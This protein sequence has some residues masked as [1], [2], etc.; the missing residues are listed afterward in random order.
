[1]VAQKP[2]TTRLFQALDFERPIL[3]LIQKIQD[4]E[5]F[6]ENTELDLSS[7]IEKMRQQSEDLTRQVFSSLNPW[8]RVQ[9]ARHPERPV[10]TDYAQVLFQDLVEVHGDRCFGDDRAILTAFATIDGIR[11]LLMGHRKGKTT[12]DRL[13]CNFGCPNPEGYRKAL[14]KMRLA[15]KFGL[16]IVSLINTPG[17]Y[18]GVEAEERG[19]AWAIA[20]N[21]FEMAKLRTPILAVVVGE[22]GS[23]GALGIGVADRLLMLENSYYSVIS[24]E[25]CAA[26][27]W[28]DKDHIAEAAKILKL[29]AEDLHRFGIIDELVPEPLGGAHRD[30]ETMVKTLRERIASQLCQLKSIPTEA[31][32]QE[33]YAK[34]RRLGQ[35]RRDG[36]P[37]GIGVPGEDPWDDLEDGDS[38]DAEDSGES[39][40]IPE[41]PPQAV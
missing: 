6:S 2:K 15:E 9:L 36:E 32:L 37:I 19:Q 16:P 5:R 29:T 3:D 8:Q 27:L 28:K 34:L 20:Q 17:A 4:L 7:Q 22:G 21:I 39:G 23:G 18:P 1:M 12:K 33:R 35:F 14:Q 41:I 10:V 38:S 13:E 30:P 25:G 11:V 31:L 40:E 26:I 24:P